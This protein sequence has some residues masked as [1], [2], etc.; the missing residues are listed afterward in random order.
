MCSCLKTESDYVGM[1]DGFVGEC[2]RQNIRYAELHFTPYN[3][4][5]FGIGAGRALDVV[6]ER[7]AMAETSGGPVARIIADIPSEAYPESAVF[8]AEFLEHLANP[9]VV[10]IGLGGPEKGY[11]RAD[12]APAFER[13]RRAGYPAVAHAGE[14]G[15]AG[16]VREAVLDLKVRRVQHGVHAVEDM[17]VLRLLADREICCDVALTS[18]ACLTPFVDMRSH[19]IRRMIE[20]GVP[21]TLSTDDPP[22]FGTDLVRE[23]ERAHNEVGLGLEELWQ[24]NLNGL[25]FGLADPGLRRRLMLEFEEEGRALGLGR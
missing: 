14:T 6:T 7:L 11:P 19:P 21:V 13:A 24:I 22:F 5:K 4:E 8:T 2:R 20:A 25:R 10:A 18:N 12:F 9:L 16:H 15:G 3:H 23:Y 17:E 1:V